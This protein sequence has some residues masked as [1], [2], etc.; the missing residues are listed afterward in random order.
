MKELGILGNGPNDTVGD[1][2]E[3]RV[4]DFIARVVPT[5]EAAGVDTI[6]AN[7]TAADLVT[8]QFI[9]PSIGL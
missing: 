5:F 4:T 2:D 9:D 3:A 6:K 8:N 1:S 7:L